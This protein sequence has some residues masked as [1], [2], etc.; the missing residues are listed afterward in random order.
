MENNLDSL[1][2]KTTISGYKGLKES[3]AVRTERRRP[4]RAGIPTSVPPPGVLCPGEG[5]GREDG[6]PPF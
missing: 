4:Q 5:E 3:V 2:P 1:E 6:S